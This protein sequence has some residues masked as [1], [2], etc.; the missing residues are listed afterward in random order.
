MIL[1]ISDGAGNWHMLGGIQDIKMLARTCVIKSLDDLKKISTSD[2][3]SYISK[4]CFT[5]DAQ[6]EVGFLEYYR[7]DQW[8]TALFTNVAYVM[9]DHGDTVEKVAVAN[10]RKRR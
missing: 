1:K 7:Q 4:D 10:I 5:V 2:T 3:I 9:N 8:N 6:L